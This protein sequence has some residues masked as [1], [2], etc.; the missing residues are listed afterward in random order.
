MTNDQVE[1]VTSVSFEEFVQELIDDGLDVPLITLVHDLEAYG[2]HIH[3]PYR[4]YYPIDSYVIYDGLSRRA[5]QILQKLI[6]DERLELVSFVGGHGDQVVPHGTFELDKPRREAGPLNEFRTK[7]PVV[8][9][10][11]REVLV[12]IK[13][14]QAALQGRERFYEERR[15]EANHR[16]FVE[17]SLTEEREA[18][19]RR[20]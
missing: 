1:T 2:V 4:A 5:G 18:R 16:V 9:K 19:V 10:R 6:E 7:P 13:P 12:R 20:P 8:G 11:D 15:D 17:H 3:G 14:T